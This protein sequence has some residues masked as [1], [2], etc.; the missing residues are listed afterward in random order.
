MSWQCRVAQVVIF[1]YIHYLKD[2]Q[3]IFEMPSAAVELR[4]SIFERPL[5]MSKRYCTFIHLA[6]RLRRA[7]IFK[8]QDKLNFLKNE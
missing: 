5:Q 4:Q 3:E 1:E 6:V 2:L 8:Q 7:V